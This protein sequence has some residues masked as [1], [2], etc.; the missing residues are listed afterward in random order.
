MAFSTSE[1]TGEAAPASESAKTNLVPSLLRQ[2]MNPRIAANQSS[3]LLWAGAL[4]SVVAFRVAGRRW[5]KFSS[6]Y[7]RQRDSRPS[8]LSKLA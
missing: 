5:F 2:L 8:T 4:G 7:V 6:F 1:T 3:E